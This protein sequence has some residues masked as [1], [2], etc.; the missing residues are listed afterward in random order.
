VQ[1]LPGTEISSELQAIG[2]PDITN[3]CGLTEVP[4]AAQGHVLDVT[5]G[6]FHGQAIIGPNRDVV[7]WPEVRMRVTPVCDPACAP[8]NTVPAHALARFSATQI[9]TVR[10][11]FSDNL[12]YRPLPSNIG[13]AVPYRLYSGFTYS[14]ALYRYPDNNADIFCWPPT[15]A[16]QSPFSDLAGV[17]H[18]VPML[19]EPNRVLD[20]QVTYEYACV[21]KTPDLALIPGATGYT[22][23]CWGGDG[24]NA[25]INFGT[26]TFASSINYAIPP[27]EWQG[28]FSR[29]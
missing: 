5:M 22:I 21:L 11:D 28:H 24:Y 6:L 4:A 27:A 15:V 8:A 2:C 16:Y 10:G 25:D 20:M 12:G 23:Y 1:V 26:G 19:V 14:C 13:G 29:M 17:D 7:R 3:A 9:G 18:R